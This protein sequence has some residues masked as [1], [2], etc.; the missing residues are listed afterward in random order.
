MLN[1]FGKVSLAFQQELWKWERQH[2]DELTEGK[3]RKYQDFLAK[4]GGKLLPDHAIKL[5]LSQQP[6]WLMWN[7]FDQ[8]LPQVPM[9]S[10]ADIVIIGCGLT[11]SSAFYHL[12]ESGLTVLLLDEADFPCAQSSGK[13]GGNFQLLSE[14][15][16]GSYDGIVAERAEILKSHFP[17]LSEAKLQYHAERDSKRIRNFTMQNVERLTD[18]VNRESIECD[19][20]PGGWLQLASSEHEVNAMIADEALIPKEMERTTSAAMVKRLGLSQRPLFPGRW[21]SRS[22]NYHPVKF[23][24][25]LLT[26]TLQKKGKMFYPSTKVHSIQKTPEGVDIITNHQTIH[27][28]KVIVATNAFTPFVLPE[29]KGVVTCTPSQIINI[30]HV[31]QGLRGATV[32]EHQGDIYYNFP[33]STVYKGKEHMYGMLHYGFDFD[34]QVANPYQIQ[35]SKSRFQQMIKQIHGRFPDT[36]DQ[37][38]SRCWA[39]PLGMTSDRTPLIGFVNPQVIVGVG[40]NG[41]GGSWCVETGYVIA[42]MARTGKENPKVPRPIFSPLRFFHKPEEWRP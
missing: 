31:K 1:P 14:S 32:T 41:F 5:P 29:F 21:I 6:F 23:V 8:F 19:F 13:N 12:R 30:E 33:K 35:R 37:P 26:C 7:S 24:H 2:Y 27:A 25:G 34:H 22:G 16:I 10:Q 11:G 36:V 40:F 4:M 9:P 39:G 17:H 38:P 20:S 28:S 42:E 18:I 3:K 15:Y